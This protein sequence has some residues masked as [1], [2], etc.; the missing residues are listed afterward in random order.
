MGVQKWKNGFEYNGE[1]KNNFRHGHGTLWRTV[2]GEKKRIYEGGWKHGFRDGRGIVTYPDG[3]RYEGEF[4]AGVRNGLGKME[5]AAPTTANKLYRNGDV[6]SGEWLDDKRHGFGVLMCP[7]GDRYEGF[8]QNDKKEGEGKYYYYETRKVYFGEWRNDIAKCGELKEVDPSGEFLPDLALANVEALIQQ[9]KEELKLSRVAEK[10]RKAS[11]VEG[12]FTQNQL[13]S[14]RHFYD[15]ASPDPM[16]YIKLN[17]LK[18]IIQKL[19][20]RC[21]EDEFQLLVKEIVGDI[22]VLTKHGERP[23]NGIS[24]DEFLRCIHTLMRTHP[25]MPQHR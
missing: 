4:K 23:K 11:S 24:F 19:E 17:A 2:D 10:V 13:D 15:A 20:F 14:L 3:S 7:N 25:P 9:R 5:Y 16:G 8:W 12:L 18:A 21:T 6:Y 1:W 22:T